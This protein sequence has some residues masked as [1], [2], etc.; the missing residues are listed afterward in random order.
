MKKVAIIGATGFIGKSLARLMVADNHFEMYL[1][2]RTEEKIAVLKD[3]LKIKDSTARVLPMEAFESHEYDV[4]INCGGIG[5]PSELKKRPEEIFKV[6]EE[7]DA[8]IMKYQEKNPETLYINLSSGVVHSKDP[9]GNSYS[10]A[11]IDSEAKHRS[12]PHL[13]I[14]D[15]RVFSFFSAFIDSDGGFFMSDVVTCLKENRV[16]DTSADDMVRDYVCPADLLALIVKVIEKKTLND[17][18][19]VYSAGFVSKFELLEFLGREFGLRYNIK[20]S[21]D[22]SSPTGKKNVYFAN[23]KKA[24]ILGYVPEYTS[25]QGI[26]EEILNMK[27]SV[28]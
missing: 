28:L 23:D 16:L 17:A 12:M 7:L 9:T 19:D 18:F 11:K 27:P 15:L 24:G 26:K 21:F 10:M 25:I 4:V 5:S 8:L 2:A 22:D 14:V 3:E 6:T 13:N 1:F 20:K